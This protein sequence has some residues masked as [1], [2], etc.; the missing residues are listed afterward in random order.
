MFWE[1]K[2]AGIYNYIVS[3]FKSTENTNDFWQ[4]NLKTNVWTPLNS[5]IPPLDSH[6]AV[7]NETDMIVYGGFL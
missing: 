1:V 5:S 6:V 2:Q 7:V 3:N 4:F